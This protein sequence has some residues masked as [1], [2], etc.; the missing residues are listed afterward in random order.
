ME[1]CSAG[2]LGL[3][4]RGKD[5]LN[6]TPGES[7]CRVLF[8]WL[9]EGLKEAASR[10]K[11]LFGLLVLQGVQSVMVD[12]AGAGTLGMGSNCTTVGSR[13]TEF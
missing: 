10:K 5:G 7:L 9:C 3:E 6:G 1:G 13:V 11:S 2:F 12:S 4:L 8:S